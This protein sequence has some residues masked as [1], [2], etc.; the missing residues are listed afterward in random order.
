M[1]NMNYDEKTQNI[2]LNNSEII[3]SSFNS[4]V[5]KDSNQNS[6]LKKIISVNNLSESDKSTLRDTAEKLMK[7]EHEN[8]RKN[9][10]FRPARLHSIRNV[11][12][13]HLFA[14]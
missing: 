1:I 7:Y 3:S 8:L 5:I 14:T 12:S 6:I 11:T 2:D 10:A 13:G 9:L 4:K